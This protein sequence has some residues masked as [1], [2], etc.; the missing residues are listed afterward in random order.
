VNNYT[1]GAPTVSLGSIPQYQ[2][3]GIGTANVAGKVQGPTLSADQAM[4]YL[5]PK[6]DDKKS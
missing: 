2:A 5:A 4:Q 3:A 6:K 1:K